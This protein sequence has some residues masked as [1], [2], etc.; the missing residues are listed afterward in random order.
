MDIIKKG[1]G[2]TKTIRNVSRFR[3]IMSV[4]AQNGLDE[5]IIR[6]GLHKVVPGFV[7]PRTQSEHNADESSWPFI[8]GNRLRRSF[9]QLGP[10]F[11]KLGQLLSTR[12]DLFPPEFIQ[13]MRY[14]RDRAQGVPFADALKAIDKA[15][16]R[17]HREVFQSIDPEA[18][19]TASVGLVYRAKLKAGDDVVIKLRRPGVE[20]IIP[21][22][23]AIIE[24]IVE[25][26]ERASDE[27]KYLGVSRVIEEFGNNLYS[28]LD[29]HLEALNCKRIKQNLAALDQDKIFYIPEVYDDFT[30]RDL[31]VL[32]ELKGTPFSDSDKIARDLDKIQ[33][34]LIDGIHIF[35]KT[36]LSD[37]IFH[38]DLHG[39]NFFLLEDGRIGLVDFGLVGHLSKKSRTSL[40]AIL[41]SMTTHNYENLVFEFLDIAEYEKV[42][43][44]DRLVRDIKDALANFVGLS[45][46]QINLS[47]LFSKTA[48]ALARHKIYLPREWFIVF[49]ALMTLDGVGQS[50][51]M[52]IDVFEIIEKNL[53]DVTK[54]V[55][56]KEG[57]LEEG[58]FTSRDFLTSLRILPRHL[59][60]FM[61]ELAR[62]NYAFRIVHT[63]H[64]ASFRDLRNAVV[65]LGN[66]F[67]SG[68]FFI[69]GTLMIEQSALGDWYAI[70]K[71]SWL[72]WALGGVL[73]FSGLRILR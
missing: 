4:F 40:I 34:K 42:P 22:D 9:E 47:L 48:K 20:K 5:F 63:G 29:F 53:K 56:S 37:G 61:K 7:L 11:I 13:Q 35:I 6:S 57:L 68:I 71:L 24:F 72:F 50:L 14:L 46:R 41:Y 26:L 55:F 10:S 69:S 43:D 27:I 62:N 30:C 64:E 21:V 66:I 8:I 67:I 32:E 12:E 58:I 44:I 17:D 28:E 54:E 33:E 36:L 60:W 65:F 31:L 70:S 49:R 2:I 52:D 18:I 73:L 51:N 39:G 16:G 3:E 15:L 45:A 1:I 59:R 25:R 23:L 19:G 38:A